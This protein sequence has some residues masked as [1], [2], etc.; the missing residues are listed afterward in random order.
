MASL[1]D[2]FGRF[3]SKVAEA[4]SPA[5]RRRVERGQE[6]GKSRSEARGHGRTPIKQ[7]ESRAVSDR[8]AYDK[9]LAVLSRMR[10]GESLTHAAREEQTTPDTVLRYAGSALTRTAK[11]RYVAKRRDRLYR[12]MRF[13]DEGG[14]VWIEPADSHEAS[15]LGEYWNAVGHYLAT[16]DDAP[17]ARFRWMRLR[18]RQKTS[19]PFVT[20]LDVLDRLG[21][22]GELSFESIYHMT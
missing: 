10:G 14:E 2:L 6:Q 12:Y 7:W 16:G 5:Y 19:L 20:D 1:R 8:E 21:W 4:L 17:L 11:G 3:V 15:K 13:L 9:S 18:T 22:A